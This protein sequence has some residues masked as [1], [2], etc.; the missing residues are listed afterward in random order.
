M[1]SFGEIIIG[2]MKTCKLRVIYT[3]RSCGK[4][5]EVYISTCEILVIIWTCKIIW[6]IIWATLATSETIP[7]VIPYCTLDQ[8]LQ[9]ESSNTILSKKW[10]LHHRKTKKEKTQNQVANIY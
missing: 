2:S 7:N 10:T 4:Q 3:L 6:E 1:K 9:G 5:S 8:K